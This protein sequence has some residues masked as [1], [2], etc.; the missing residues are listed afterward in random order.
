MSAAQD[1]CKSCG[2]CCQGYL[3]D[4]VEIDAD[5]SPHPALPLVRRGEKTVFLSSHILSEVSQ[6]CTRVLIIHE[7]RIV[8]SGSPEELGRRMAGRGV[9]R[10]RTRGPLEVERLKA[11]AEV[12]DADPVPGAEGEFL[13][14]VTDGDRAAPAVA[15]EVLAAGADLLELRQEAVDLEQVFRKLTLGDGDA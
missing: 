13:V 11:L 7:G 4:H 12:E 1:L 9:L 14:S 15:R 3:F 8:G 6:I 5:E 2:L 10:L